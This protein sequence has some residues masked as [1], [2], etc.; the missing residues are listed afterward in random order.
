M[1]A[2]VSVLALT[3]L[4]CVRPAFA[5]VE[6]DV[7]ATFEAFVAA[8]NAHDPA[9]VRELLVDSPD[10]L[11]VTRGAAIWGRD[12]ALKR[13]E[14]LYQGT[15]K[16]SPDMSAL[17]VIVLGEKTAQLFVPTVF[18]IGPAG[19]PAPDAPFL[20]NQTLV[21]TETGWRIASIL[22]IPVPVAVAQ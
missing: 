3:T 6:D 10:F 4:L 21:R 15:W 14:K 16:L 17:K 11:W 2:I 9:A 8:Q 18:N 5:G 1:K 13:F 12:A 22:P 19:Q 7:K 20:V